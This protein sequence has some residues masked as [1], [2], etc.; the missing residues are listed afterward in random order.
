MSRPDDIPR[1]LAEGSDCAQELR[2]VLGSASDDS[3]T[4][5]DL[6]RLSSGLG[7]LV[8]SPPP[9]PAPPVAPAAKA[10]AS[11]G[12]VGSATK[13]VAGIVCALGVAGG[14][15][16]LHRDVSPAS[17]VAS[18]VAPPPSVAPGPGASPEAP[19]PSP[20]GDVGNVPEPAPTKE[21]TPRP[22]GAVHEA[23][24]GAAEETALLGRA[25]DALKRRDG[26]T[27]L[28]LARQHT[29]EYPAGSYGEEF[30]RIA[31]EGYVLSGASALAEARARRFFKRYP[32]SAYR[33]RIEGLLRHGP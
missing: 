15:Y 25:L 33:G 26:V 8:A 10:L 3:P 28:A 22:S 7:A 6:A 20:P 24:R 12:G 13:V 1:L 17:V 14:A 9:S 31:I 32:A 4:A 27:A 23:P 30:D 18:S 5:E 21:N 11:A 16:A 19:P 29:E 2:E